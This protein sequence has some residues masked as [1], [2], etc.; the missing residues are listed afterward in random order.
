[1]IKLKT[2]IEQSSAGVMKSI[3]TQYPGILQSLK[4]T[5][6][7]RKALIMFTPDQLKDAGQKFDEFVKRH[8]ERKVT[9]RG[10]IRAKSDSVTD[11]T[12]NEREPFNVTFDL[13]I[14]DQFGEAETTNPDLSPAVLA[15]LSAALKQQTVDIKSAFPEI[16]TVRFGLV[17]Y[18]IQ[19]TTS[20]VGSDESN[21]TLRQGRYKTMKEAIIAAAKTLDIAGV[22][23]ATEQTPI[24]EP[25]G[26]EMDPKFSLDKRQKDPVLKAEYEKIYG[27]HRTA[28]I[29]VTLDQKLEY[30]PESKET[31]T[32]TAEVMFTLDKNVSNIEIFRK[33]T[34]KPWSYKISKFKA[35]F[36]KRPRNTSQKELKC[37]FPPS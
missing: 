14:S 29:T 23:A 19:A 36:K 10:R 18:Q 33:K 11:V 16:F 30:K 3:P 12:E 21:Q 24:L 4:A 22:A 6:N 31:T 37:W 15:L 34:S 28:S 20:R 17:Q 9:E 2:L 35:K 25:R 1:M 7:T 13:D 32:Q 26:P 8:G 27:P 5:P